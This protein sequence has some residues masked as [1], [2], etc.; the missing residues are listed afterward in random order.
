MGYHI[1]LGMLLRARSSAI[2]CGSMSFRQRV[3]Y[4]KVAHPDTNPAGQ[5]LKLIFSR[6]ASIGFKIVSLLVGFVECRHFLLYWGDIA[7]VS[8]KISAI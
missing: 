1:F 5:G 3:L 2:I 7:P 8:L 6:G 4:F